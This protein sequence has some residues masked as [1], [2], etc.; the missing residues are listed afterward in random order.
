VKAKG[1]GFLLPIVT[2]ALVLGGG[3]AVY[4]SMF[5]DESASLQP[6]SQKGDSS[7]WA[8]GGDAGDSLVVD[9]GQALTELPVSDTS[10]ASETDARRGAPDAGAAEEVVDVEP[11]LNT[12]SVPR[13][14]ISQAGAGPVYV[15]GPGVSG[16]V[17]R[18]S[19]PLGEGAHI[20]RLFGGKTPLKPVLRFVRRGEKLSVQIPK[21][22]D[23]FFDVKCGGYPRRTAPTGA[24][25]VGRSLTCQIFSRDGDKMA[26]KI[27]KHPK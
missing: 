20:F 2:V 15:K 27:T 13:I 11:R 23:S 25:K 17:A 3:F 4:D 19:K 14:T 5:A 24:M 22:A 26:F 18:K 10:T 21:P 8:V 6:P 1:S 12:P 9:A 16:T 7:G